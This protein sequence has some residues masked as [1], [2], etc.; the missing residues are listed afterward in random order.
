MKISEIL[1]A[2][3][4]V[5]ITFMPI[6]ILLSALYSLLG[7][8]IGLMLGVIVFSII[9]I[10]ASGRI[11]SSQRARVVDPDDHPDLYEALREVTWKAGTKMPRLVLVPAGVPNSFTTG[12]GSDNAVLALT[13]GTLRSLN[14]D[15]IKALMGH[16]MG[17]IMNGDVLPYTVASFLSGTLISVPMKMGKTEGAF[18]GLFA[19][20]AGWII[21]IATNP[22][23]EFAADYRALPLVGKDPL[24][25][26]LRKIENAVELRPLK[27]GNPSMAP[28]YAVNPFKG[29]EWAKSFS[30]HP[31]TEERIYYIEEAWREMNEDSG[32]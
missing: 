18:F 32:N 5:E 27:D 21:K 6:T 8:I 25:S 24:I 3:A 23:D 2:M 30:H 12:M 7:M 31:P 26:A 1:E 29:L 11:L 17:H 9:A 20:P 10:I 16:E 13:Y 19:R 22:E 14:I 28:L 4:V 15:E